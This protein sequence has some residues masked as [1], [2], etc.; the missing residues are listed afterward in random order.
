MRSIN[1]D[2][3]HSG[4]A[5]SLTLREVAPT[6]PLLMLQVSEKHNGMSLILPPSGIV[7]RNL[8]FQ[9]MK[10]A[11]SK[12]WG[13]EICIYIEGERPERLEKM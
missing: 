10:R 1:R 12:D 2:R 9:D 6:Q 8:K 4:G 3:R 5:G 13:F 11:K 7:S